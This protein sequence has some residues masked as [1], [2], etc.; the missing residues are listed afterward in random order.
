MQELILRMNAAGKE[1]GDIFNELA[2][3]PDP[4]NI[5]GR[6]ATNLLGTVLIYMHKSTQPSLSQ[7]D[8]IIKIKAYLSECVDL[9]VGR[10]EAEGR[11]IEEFIRFVPL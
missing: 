4:E 3:T 9:V 5:A 7:E 2:K 6:F 8:A 11:S 1:V 10:A